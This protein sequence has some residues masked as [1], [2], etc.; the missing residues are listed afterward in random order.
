MSKKLLDN[1]WIKIYSEN[2]TNIEIICW[3]NTTHH[4]TT[5]LCIN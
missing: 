2:Y 1:H 3:K 5:L 4:Y